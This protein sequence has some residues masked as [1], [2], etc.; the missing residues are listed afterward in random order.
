MKRL[1]LYIFIG[2]FLISIY[3]DLT[4]GL[5]PENTTEQTDENRVEKESLTGIRA[6]VDKG[7]T[8]LSVV[9]K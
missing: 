6:E 7:D 4:T 1:G 3:K 2:L 9:E 8:V 5:L